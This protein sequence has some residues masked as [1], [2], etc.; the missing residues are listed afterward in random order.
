MELNRHLNSRGRSLEMEFH[1]LEKRYKRLEERF[2][3]QLVRTVRPPGA[4]ARQP[5]QISLHISDEA[6][7]PRAEEIAHALRTHGI[8]VPE[9]QTVAPV[10]QSAVRYFRNEDY[11]D[12]QK[13]AKLLNAYLVVN[14]TLQRVSM[15]WRKP[16]H[17][18]Q[19]EIWIESGAL[20][21]AKPAKASLARVSAAAPRASL[22][23]AAPAT[24]LIALSNDQDCSAAV[25]SY[26]TIH[27]AL[28]Q[29][30]GPEFQ[31]G[32]LKLLSG[33]GGGQPYFVTAYGGRFSSEEAESLLRQVRG[34]QEVSADASPVLKQFYQEQDECFVEQQLR[35]RLYSLAEV[36]HGPHVLM[37]PSSEWMGT[38]AALFKRMSSL[39]TAA[40]LNPKEIEDLYRQG[41][42][43]IGSRIAAL[44]AIQGAPKPAHLPLL[45]ESIRA[46]IQSSGFEQLQALQALQ[47]L[48]NRKRALSRDQKQD[49]LSALQQAW[50][51]NIA[52]VQEDGSRKEIVQ[53]LLKSL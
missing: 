14:P 43:P 35:T 44:A 30:L 20:G 7:R 13:I 6:Q 42:N 41:R 12:A 5:V 23:S 25:D 32:D 11:E 46:P 2:P 22:V 1:A 52:H 27:G 33:S 15:P 18:K 16:P 9:V 37:S 47:A 36:Y 39:A 19:L 29:A 24:Y 21:A 8:V 49:S 50:D 38:E 40:A 48:S 34:Q 26:L 45:L 4:Q 10:P 53:Q 51:G 31:H 3:E 17:E 28:A